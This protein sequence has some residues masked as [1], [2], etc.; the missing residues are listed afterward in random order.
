METTGDPRFLGDPHVRALLSDP[1]GTATPG[2][3]G[4]LVL[5][6]ALSTSSAPANTVLS[7][8]YHTA[9]TLAVYADTLPVLVIG[10]RSSLELLLTARL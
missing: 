10:G 6:S 9:R 3:C 5:P 4:V 1:G 8:L 7:R 2:H